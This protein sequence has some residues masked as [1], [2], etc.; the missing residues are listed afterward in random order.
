M[1]LFSQG[2]EVTNP[3]IA[4]IISMML[5]FLKCIHNLSSKLLLDSS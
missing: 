2:L 5:S 1:N 4:E 3:T